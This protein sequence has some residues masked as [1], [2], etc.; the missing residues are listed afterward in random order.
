MQNWQIVGRARQAYRPVLT[1]FR[2]LPSRLQTGTLFGA[3][4]AQ[5][6]RITTNNPR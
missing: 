1:F 2:N 5:F 6:F 3:V 4:T